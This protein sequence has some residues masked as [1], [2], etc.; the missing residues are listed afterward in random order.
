MLRK[1]LISLM[2]AWP[3]FFALVVHAAF[4]G[5]CLT[6]FRSTRLRGFA[7]L[8]G[9]EAV[10]AVLQLPHLWVMASL[11][12]HGPAWYGARV[13]VLSAVSWF[14]DP[15]LAAAS[16]WGLIAL[17]NACRQLTRAR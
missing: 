4:A 16:L 6:A 11:H 14:V 1:V 2:P 13:A 9:A 7:L 12:V 8:G 10:R 5:V 15:V 3:A 17:A